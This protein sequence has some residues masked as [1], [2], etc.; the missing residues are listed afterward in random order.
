MNKNKKGLKLK[1]FVKDKMNIFDLIIVLA[2]IIEYICYSI[3]NL[4]SNSKT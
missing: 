4:S 2:S 3:L 1:I